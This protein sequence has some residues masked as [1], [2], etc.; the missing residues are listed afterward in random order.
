[1]DSS[2]LCSWRG[3]FIS[4][5]VCTLDLLSGETMPSG[6]RLHSDDTRQYKYYNPNYS[7]YPCLVCAVASCQVLNVLGGS[8]WRVCLAPCWLCRSE[9]LPARVSTLRKSVEVLWTELVRIN[10]GYDRRRRS[11]RDHRG[12]HDRR[13]IH[14]RVLHEEPVGVLRSQ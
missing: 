7:R 2:A 9:D 8:V 1:M 6:G 12:H 11:R 13:R 3:R 5:N 4:S 10:N 14:R